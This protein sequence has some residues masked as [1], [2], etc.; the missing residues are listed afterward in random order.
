EMTSSWALVSDAN[1][2]EAIANFA[3]SGDLATAREILGTVDVPVFRA[4]GLVN[5][6]NH[7]ATEGAALSAWGDAMVA[8]RIARPAVVAE[9]LASGVEIYARF[10]RADRAHALRANIGELDLTWEI[11]RFAEE[12]VATRRTRA[13]SYERT[14]RMTWM[15]YRPKR[16]ARARDWTKEDA[17]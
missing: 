2:A 6:A 10:N 3:S 15:L 7:E 4:R 1:R 9:V 5:V 13:P 11:E 8:A 16:I 14:L 17:A 12:Y